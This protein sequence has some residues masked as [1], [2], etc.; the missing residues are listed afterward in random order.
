MVVNTTP[1]K[2]DVEMEVGNEKQVCEILEKLERGGIGAFGGIEDGD[3]KRL[4]KMCLDN[5]SLLTAC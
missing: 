2:I 3:R 4:N 1:V 5:V